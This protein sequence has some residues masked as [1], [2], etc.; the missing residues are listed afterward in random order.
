MRA[1]SSFHSTEASW[2]RAC[3]AAL[4]CGGQRQ[5]LG[6]VGGGLGEHRL[7]GAEQRQA[8]GV[9]PALALGQCDRGDAGQIPGQHRGAPHRGQ[10]HPG[11]LGQ[12]VGD[13]ALQGAVA[14][15]AH[16]EPAEQVLL[17]L[18]GPAEQRPELGHPGRLGAG[19]TQ[20]VE[21]VERGVD[22]GDFELGHRGRWHLDGRDGSPAD[23]DPALSWGSGQ[24]GRHDRHLGPVQAGEQLGEC[25]HLAGA[26][27]RGRDLGRRGYDIG[28]PHTAILAH[29][30]PA[31]RSSG[32]AVCA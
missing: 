13:Q 9:K 30:E 3:V 15:F 20:G 16:E 4:A 10:R 32:E 31:G 5:R 24:D 21:P 25:R 29:A 22:V 6:H 11:C 1:P 12:R 17:G 27:P 26:C 7:H 23:A 2:S 14:Q 28:E 19:A 8:D 18:R